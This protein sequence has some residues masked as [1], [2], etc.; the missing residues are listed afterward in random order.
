MAFDRHTPAR[1]KGLRFCI[2]SFIIKIIVTERYD[3]CHEELERR[4]IRNLPLGRGDKRTGSCDLVSYFFPGGRRKDMEP[5]H[6]TLCFCLCI[7]KRLE[8][9]FFSLEGGEDL[10]EE[11]GFFRR[12]RGVSAVF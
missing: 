8:P 6:R 11:H 9:G 3:G 2:P 1:I 12:C 7:W 5:D 10:W 4:R